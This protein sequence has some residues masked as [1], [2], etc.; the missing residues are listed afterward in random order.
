M[1]IKARR[2]R[3][4]ER[5]SAVHKHNL[6]II[7]DDGRE[8]SLTKDNMWPADKKRLSVVANTSFDRHFCYYEVTVLPSED[9]DQSLG[10]VKTSKYGIVYV[11]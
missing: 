11:G 2:A 6:H 7:S 5:W 3:I 4:I 9:P 10:Y 1:H 8:I